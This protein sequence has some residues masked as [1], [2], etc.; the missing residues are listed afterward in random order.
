MKTP[1]AVVDILDTFSA[2]RCPITGWRNVICGTYQTITDAVNTQHGTSYTS[3]DI[4]NGLTWLHEFGPDPKGLGMYISK[5][6]PGG[7]KTEVI[8]DDPTKTSVIVEGNVYMRVIDGQ[9]LPPE[10]RRLFILGQIGW[11]KY[12]LSGIRNDITDLGMLRASYDTKTPESRRT[13]RAL[14][15]TIDRLRDEVTAVEDLAKAL[16]AAL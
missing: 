9:T 10:K 1:Q 16:Q 2:V 11:C 8:F 5:T 13:G 4:S 12:R 6:G 14:Q 15:A 3:S 7:S